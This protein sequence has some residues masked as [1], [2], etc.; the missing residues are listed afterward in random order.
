MFFSIFLDSYFKEVFTWEP[1]LEVVARVISGVTTAQFFVETT[2]YATSYAWHL[3]SSPNWQYGWTARASAWRRCSF[4]L[5]GDNTRDVL[6][7]GQQ[8]CQFSSHTNWLKILKT[9]YFFSNFM[10]AQCCKNFADSW[11]AGFV[12]L[13]DFA[14]EI[15]ADKEPDNLGSGETTSTLEIC[16]QFVIHCHI[17]ILYSFI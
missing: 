6:F 2:N 17:R 1:T 11:Q 14:R 15:L 13:A 3:N 8:V 5:M 12:K 9:E 7:N 4:R 10:C 16:K